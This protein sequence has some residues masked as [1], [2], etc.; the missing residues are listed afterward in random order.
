MLYPLVGIG[1]EKYQARFFEDNSEVPFD[2]V[3]ANPAL[4]NAI[5][6]VDF[7]NRFFNY[8]LGAGVQFSSAK[9]PAHSIG[10]Q[11]GYTG[12]F[13]KNDWRSSDD[14]ALQNAPEDRL[15]RFHVSLVFGFKPAFKH[16]M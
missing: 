16:R 9:H 10:L 14:Q 13:K 1:L 11:A 15:S 3:L 7:K 2:N 8:R 12:S 6:P 4:R 5:R